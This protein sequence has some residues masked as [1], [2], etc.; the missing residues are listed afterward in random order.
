MH[1]AKIGIHTHIVRFRL[2]ELY[3]TC[4]CRTQTL[5]K[6]RCKLTYG[7]ST[8]SSDASCLLSSIRSDASRSQAHARCSLLVVQE[9]EEADDVCMYGC[10]M[11]IEM[12]VGL[13]SMPASPAH[14]HR[15][16]ERCHSFGKSLARHHLLTDYLWP[17][18]SGLRATNNSPAALRGEQAGIRSR[19]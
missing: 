16:A 2:W 13:F 12:H 17:F 1:V 4:R 18:G 19:L 15:N 8:S 9:G 10:C 6:K 11:L 5:F 3:L 7:E 14:V